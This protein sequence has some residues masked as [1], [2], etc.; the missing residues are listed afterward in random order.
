M[1]ITNKY[2]RLAALFLLGTLNLSIAIVQSPP[3][4]VKQPPGNEELLFQVKSR[5]DENDKPFVIECEAE[6]E[7]GPEYRWEKNGKKFN[8]QV[9]DNRISKQPGRGTLVITSPKT[10]DIGQYM[11]YADNEHGTATSNSVFVRQSILNNF[12]EQ[13]PITKTIE[14][15]KPFQLPCEA[16]DGWPKPNV[17]WMIQSTNG[18][19]K[20]INS[21]RLTVDPEG[22]LWFSNVTKRDNSDEFLY[23]CSAASFFR[24]E[25]KLGNRVF[26]QVIQSGSSAGLQNKHEPEKQYVTRKNHIAYR[27]KKVKMWCIFGGTP[28]PEMRWT[29]KGGALPQGRTNYDNYGKTLVI[30]HVDY[31]DEGDYTCE[32]S[33]GVG[34]AKSYSINLKVYAAPYFTKKPDSKTAA[35]GEDVMFEC[36]AGGF[37]APKIKWIHNGLPIEKAPPNPRRTITTNSI[38]L[39]NLTKQDTGNYGCNATAEEVGGYVYKDFF[40]NVLALEP[41]II[42]PP[43][44]ELRTVTGS[45]VTLTCKTFGSPTPIVKWFHGVDELTGNRFNITSDGSLVISDVKF[46][47]DGDYL[48]NATNKLGSISKSGSLIVKSRTHITKGPQPYEV[49]AGDEATFR[50]NAFTDTDLTLTINWLKDGRRIDF[51]TEPRFFRTND[52]SLTILETKELDSGS[53]T[54]QAMTELD[55]DQETAS[56]IVQDVPNPPR[57]LWVECN[58]KDA[59]VMW[60][61]QGDNRAPILTYKIQYNTTF[62]SDTWE[63]ATDYVPATATTFKVSMSPWSNYTFRVIARNKVGNSLPSGHSKI[64]LTPEDVPYQNP[65]NIMGR[66]TAPNNL[67]I[68]WTRMPQIQHNAPKF[69][70]RVYFKKDEPNEQWTIEE[71]PNWRQKELLIQN[72]PT[73]Q[74]YRIKVIAHNQIGEANVAAEEVVGYSGEAEPSEAPK[75]F[76]LREVI[77]PR[78]ALVSWE[79]VSPESINGHPKGY[80]IQTWTEA[81]GE[82]KFRE[83]VMRS[84]STQSLVRSFKPYAVNYARVLPFNGAYNGPPS[85]IITI[86]TPEGKPGPID[87]LNC[88]PM[89]SSAL[90]LQ[91][92]KPQEI[93]GI[94]TGYRIY[95]EKVTGGDIGPQREREPRIS[96]NRTDKAKLAGLQPHSKYRVTIKATTMAGEGLGYYTDCDTN[97]Q[98]LNPPSMP[99]FKYTHLTAQNGMSR[100]K[101]TWQPFVDGNPGSH[102]FVQ[103]RK[104]RETQ[105]HTTEPQL[106]ENSIVVKGLD[107]GFVYEFRVVAVDGTF[108]TASRIQNVHTVAHLP[109]QEGRGQQTLATSGWFIGMLLAIFFLLC[110]CVVVCFV[111]RNRGGK[112]AVQEQEATHG[113]VEYDEGGFM[114]YTQPLGGHHRQPSVTSELKLPPESDNESIADYADGMGDAGM[115]E[116]GSFI[117][118]YTPKREP[119]TSSAFATLV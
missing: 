76:T 78:S 48:C 27:G 1:A 73:F 44:K 100:I 64:C 51:E 93:N 33:N 2:L 23:S 96:N 116:D 117:G 10:E 5:Q 103:Y 74:K 28:L 11:C 3:Y 32:A 22:S 72:T 77:G 86:I 9:Y 61:P 31:E 39:K 113:R 6:G 71:I 63:T 54:C 99:N 81:S 101:V 46:I 115:E 59:S 7:P 118:K 83:I 8:W 47:D 18:A 50:C 105:W 88:F 69:K 68:Y 38:I 97:P 14:E 60:E 87:I 53:Y 58:S 12:K 106:N 67:V 98:S 108:Q 111:K 112:Y 52:Y 82:E 89:G 94:L 19:L 84:D 104:Q 90:L 45:Q 21:S 79:P 20:T 29:K 92:K 36:E 80:K 16:P 119:E 56:L 107:P 30:K 62:I 4:I 25:Y 57:L 110:V 13:P 55:E 85:N 17:Y 114:E 37:P 49:E 24:N 26:L 75:N 41:E 40:I 91:W 15:G 109:V 65:G 35:E 34:I 70:Y 102:F 43:E 66:G 95:Y 42:V